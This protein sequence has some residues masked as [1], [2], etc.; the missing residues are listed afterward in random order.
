MTTGPGQHRRH[1]SSRYG[2]CCNVTTGRN[3]DRPPF[4]FFLVWARP[5][6]LGVAVIAMPVPDIVKK[7]RLAGTQS[8]E[9]DP[10]CAIPTC[11]FLDIM[12]QRCYWLC[13]Q[14]PLTHREGGTLSFHVKYLHFFF[15][16]PPS[17]T[18]CCSFFTGDYVSKN[19]PLL[20]LR[21][22]DFFSSVHAAGHTMAVT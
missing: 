21:Y 4:S 10:T 19:F 17:K 8:P 14:R 3:A 9:M 2:I 1:S 22:A 15:F 20:F 13:S 18:H 5:L 12:C 11:S 7:I 6:P 16:N